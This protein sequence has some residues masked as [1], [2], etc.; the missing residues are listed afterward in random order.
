M[1]EIEPLS[2][3]NPPPDIDDASV[4]LHAPDKAEGKSFADIRRAFFEDDNAH[5][6]EAAVE[7]EGEGAAPEGAEPVKAIAQLDPNK[8]GEP[9]AAELIE[10]GEQDL[11]VEPEAGQPPADPAPTAD[12]QEFRT[13][14][15][16]RYRLVGQDG[17]VRDPLAELQGA[18]IEV[19]HDGAYR[20]IPVEKLPVYLNNALLFNKAQGSLAQA[21]QTLQ[22]REE[23]LV[24]RESDVERFFSDPDYRAKV[25]SEL[26]RLASPEGQLEQT[27]EQLQQYRQRDEQTEQ[28]QAAQMVQTQVVVPVVGRLAE[29]N[30]LVS[31]G[32]IEAM[33]GAAVGQFPPGALKL[34]RTRDGGWSPVNPAAWGRFTQI[35]KADLPAAVAAE[36]Q[37]LAG[38]KGTP[39]DDTG[40]AARKSQAA[41]EAETV[42]KELRV[43]RTAQRMPQSQ[44]LPPNR[45]RPREPITTIQ[46]G[47]R[48]LN[49]DD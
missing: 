24:R 44:G 14:D 22:Q 27:Q 8:G 48:W 42:R 18:S 17:A 37:R 20:K 2:P 29:Q 3:D 49:S 4:P 26:E 15:G 5:F 19:F 39:K 16:L 32:V 43:N 33:L 7:V 21:R 9:T 30:P 38:L 36:Q 23:E 31:Q 40:V 45:E 12:T 11:G 25:E 13:Q 47:R 34:S 46:Q 28:T 10:A 35:L 41:Q 1:A 6:A